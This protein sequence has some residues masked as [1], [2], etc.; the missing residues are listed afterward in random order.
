MLEPSP[1]SSSRGPLLLFG[2]PLLAISL[3]VSFVVLGY[4]FRAPPDFAIAVW[5]AVVGS[6]ALALVGSTVGMLWLCGQSRWRVPV[7]LLAG[8]FTLAA[9]LFFSAAISYVIVVRIAN[10]QVGQFIGH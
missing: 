6:G 7:A 5:I 4:Y 10:S 3:T 8:L 1:K 9:Y 2:A